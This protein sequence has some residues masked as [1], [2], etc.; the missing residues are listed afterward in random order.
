MTKGWWE[1]N[2][3]TLTKLIVSIESRESLTDDWGE[4]I[5]RTTTDSAGAS[6]SDDKGANED[7]VPHTPFS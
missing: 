7:D 4:I 6:A 2:F 5:D 1:L 3:T